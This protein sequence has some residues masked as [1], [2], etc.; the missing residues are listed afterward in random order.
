MGIEYICSGCTHL[1]ETDLAQPE[2]W[3]LLRDK[4]QHRR[5]P[6]CGSFAVPEQLWRQHSGFDEA[7]FFMFAGCE[8]AYACHI[9]ELLDAR[10][11]E[12]QAMSK[13]FHLIR[14]QNEALQGQVARLETA[15][16]HLIEL[17]L[18]VPQPQ[19]PDGRNADH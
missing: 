4:R 16:G 9:E 8:N 5:C 2:Q 12:G 3:P 14:L 15:L 19:K 17:A 18:P 11:E 1:F 6:R 10:C 13:C 7:L